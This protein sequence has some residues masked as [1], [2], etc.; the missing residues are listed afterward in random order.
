MIHTEQEI[1]NLSGIKDKVAV[2]TGGGSGIGLGIAMGYA[3]AGA[4]V[5]IL[6]R[7]V[8]RLAL[9]RREA[10]EYDLVLDYAECDVTDDA[11]VQKVFGDVIRRYG[12]IDIL[13][14]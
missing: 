3:A 13:V 9:A 14:N 4:R 10:L 6:G 11:E 1:K 5:I 7:S 12:Q 2:V 8:E